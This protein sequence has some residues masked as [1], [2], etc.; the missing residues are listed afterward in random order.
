MHQVGGV[1]ARRRQGTEGPAVEVRGREGGGVVRTV[2]K[3]SRADR[4]GWEAIWADNCRHFDASDMDRLSIDAL[5]VRILDPAHPMDAWLA[6][7]EAVGPD[8]VG[9][10]HTILHP[11]TF[12]LK[13]VCYLEDLFVAP[14]A[15]RRGIARALIA[16]VAEAGRL[17]GWQRIYWVTETTNV[18]A[19]RLYASLAR[20]VDQHTYA[21]DLGR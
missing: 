7:D 5:W 6:F 10:A 1:R 13:Q 12:P 18:T 20:Q 14:A 3:A 11:H 15:R 2:Q 19:Q 21:I 16:A 9:L 17:H 4:A 8:P